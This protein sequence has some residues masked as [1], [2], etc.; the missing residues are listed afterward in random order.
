MRVSRSSTT[1]PTYIY[2]TRAQR[3]TTSFI[4]LDG[5]TLQ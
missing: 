1:K 4:H 5:D 3:A 2:G